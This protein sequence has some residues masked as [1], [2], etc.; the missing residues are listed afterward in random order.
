MIHVT[1]TRPF[2]QDHHVRR[3]FEAGFRAAGPSVAQSVAPRCLRRIAIAPGSLLRALARW[4]NPGFFELE[5]R[6]PVQTRL[7]PGLSR[8][9]DS[10]WPRRLTD[11]TSTS[12][13][14]T[15]RSAGAS[16]R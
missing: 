11:H 15:T 2:N 7:G 5:R 3:S 10:F 12:G 16:S 6:G 4:G 14:S 1:D 13:Q 8:E 9:S